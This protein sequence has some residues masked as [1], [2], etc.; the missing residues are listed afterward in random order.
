MTQL[1]Y[2]PDTVQC[3][4]LASEIETFEGEIITFEH[5]LDDGL[6]HELL[7]SANGKLK[8]LVV[9]IINVYGG[10]II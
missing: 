6:L 10:K 8:C 5:E 3:R 1:Y 4:M 2:Y 9:S 7:M